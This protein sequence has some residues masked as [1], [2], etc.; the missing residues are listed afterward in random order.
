MVRLQSILTP[1][2]CLSPGVEPNTSWSVDPFGHS[3]T[4]AYLL[5]GSGIKNMVI[6]RVHYAVKRYL[7]KR[8]QLEFDWRQSWGEAMAAH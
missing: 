5:G 1:A 4:M 3:P 7:A 2:S 8:Q 6:Q